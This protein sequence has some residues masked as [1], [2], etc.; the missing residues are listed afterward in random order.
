MA[1]VTM[2]EEPDFLAP[3]QS[4]SKSLKSFLKDLSLENF[5]NFVTTVEQTKDINFDDSGYEIKQF[6]V[7]LDADPPA[8]GVGTL[9]IRLQEVQSFK[10][11][12]AFIMTDAL[13]ILS[14]WEELYFV[15]NRFYKANYD[16]LMMEDYVRKLSN[17]ELRKAE[18][19]KRL[20]DVVVI[21]DHCEFNVDKIKTFLKQCDVVFNNLKSTNDNISRQ[22]TVVGQQIEIREISR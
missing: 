22:I 20:K 16:K 9:N 1:V 13:S 14:T 15:A 17:Q 11:R 8:I 5:P 12:L 6:R 3:T 21:K 2:Q 10:D 19:D 7:L 18:V 4:V